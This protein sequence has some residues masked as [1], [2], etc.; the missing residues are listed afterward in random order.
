MASTKSDPPEIPGTQRSLIELGMA[1]AEGRF[2]PDEALRPR[3][4]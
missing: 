4:N 2:P 3:K 1:I